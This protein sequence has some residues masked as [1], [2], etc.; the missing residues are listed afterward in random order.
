MKNKFSQL[1][2]LFV[3]LALCLHADDALLKNGDFSEANDKGLP[4]EWTPNN[5]LQQ[6][7]VV[8]KEAKPEGGQQSLRID[9][10]KAAKDQGNLWQGFRNL[11]KD[12]NF[13][14]EG[15][16]KSSADGLAFL[17]V[18][19]SIDNPKSE[20][21][22]FSSDKSSAEW[23]AVKIE[24]NSGK[25][26]KALVCIRFKQDEAVVGKSAWIANLKLTEKK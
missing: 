5:D 20:T 19:L 8:D 2:S 11:K 9:I 12:T 6:T 14:L 7:L 16:L 23:K 1:A 18:K 25:C 22:R 3:L 10:T 15:M 21:G 4:K 13:I 17:Q 26:D 24:F